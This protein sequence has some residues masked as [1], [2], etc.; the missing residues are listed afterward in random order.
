MMA[1]FAQNHSVNSNGHGLALPVLDLQLA[2]GDA[3]AQQQWQQQLR[4]AVRDTGFFYVIGHGISIEQQQALLTQSKA[5]FALSEAEKQQ[6]AMINSPHFRGY[7]ARAT[8]LTRGR[9]DQRE[10]FDIMLEQQPDIAINHSWQ[11]LTGPNQWPRQLPELPAQLLQWQQQV[12]D[13]GIELLRLMLQ[14]LQ[15]PASAL[16]STLA[17][18]PY[19]HTKLIR[20]PGSDDLQGQG[21]GAHKDPG[22]LTILLQDE[23]AGLEV[24]TDAGWVSAPPLP[25]S[26]IVNIGELLELASNGYFRATMHR[27][28]SP[29]AGITRY[30]CA[31]FIAAN[32][33]STVP[34]LELPAHFA[35]EAKGPATDPQNPLFYQVGQ[36]VLKGR[37]RSHPD[38]AAA[39]YREMA[40]TSS[41][42]VLK[43][44]VS[45][46]EITPN[47]AA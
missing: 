44:I 30:S 34:L 19:V 33:A 37:L 1:T 46:A 24:E 47:V 13:L 35:A 38:V 18:A 40:I 20:Y 29:E 16:D 43:T 7:T 25:G 11:K 5:F 41:A 12:T 4:H 8:E 26:F 10:Q 31:S 39:H 9:P 32:L 6:V 21:V 2:Y 17:P 3:S 22:Y 27:V 15:L 36:N 28:I 14:A 23:H 42:P 45:T